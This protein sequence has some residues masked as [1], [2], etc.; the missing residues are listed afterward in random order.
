MDGT[1][2]RKRLGALKAEPP[3]I[4]E[5]I[6][7]TRELQLDEVAEC[8]RYLELSVEMIVALATNTDPTEM[9]PKPPL[10]GDQ[11]LEDRRALLE[12][13]GSDQC[14]GRVVEDLI[15]VLMKKE[16]IRLEDLPE[17]AR[18]LLNRRRKL[19]IALDGGNND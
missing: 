15:V 3:R 12:I 9:M 17:A 1:W 6:G 18:E 16:V 2:I 10:S 5:I 11:R 4:T 19:R 7:G 14:M 8:A 13:N